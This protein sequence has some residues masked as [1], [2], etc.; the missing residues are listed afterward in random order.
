[1]GGRVRLGSGSVLCAADCGDSSIIYGW[2]GPLI[3][4][5]RHSGLL[6]AATSVQL[7]VKPFQD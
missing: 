3:L 1:M 7:L 5:S 6:R 4:G 2:L